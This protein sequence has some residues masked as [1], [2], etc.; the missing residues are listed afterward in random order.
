MRRTAAHTNRLWRGI[1][2]WQRSVL[3]M[4]AVLAALVQLGGSSAAPGDPPD[5]IGDWSAPVRVAD[6]RRPHVA[7]VDRR[8]LLAR[9]LRRGPELRAALESADAASSRRCRTDAT[10]SAA[11]TCSFPT[12]GR[13]SS[14]VTSPPTKG[15]PT[16]RSSTRRPTRISAAPTWRSRA[17]TRRRRRCRT[18]RCSSSQATGSSRTARAR[19]TPSRTPPST[20]CR[21]STTRPRTPGRA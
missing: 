11:A 20:R 1:P 9:R 4:L 15:S 21:S 3:A 6:R 19:S 14:A 13:S 10:S 7:D 5:V 2:S 12:A 17:G 18:A 16:R 8:G